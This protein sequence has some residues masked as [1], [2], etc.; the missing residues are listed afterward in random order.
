VDALL[1]WSNPFA[2][3]AD[4]SGAPESRSKIRLLAFA[5]TG[6]CANTARACYLVTFK[7]RKAASTTNKLIRQT[8]GHLVPCCHITLHR[9]RFVPLAKQQGNTVARSHTVGVLPCQITNGNA[10]S[11]AD[12]VKRLRSRSASPCNL[13]QNSSSSAPYSAD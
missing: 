1:A 4:L 12:N 13:Y 11:P 7:Y 9:K 8:L 5:A 6:F 3:P 10:V 2:E